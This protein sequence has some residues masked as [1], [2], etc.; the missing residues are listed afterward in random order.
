MPA[1]QQA[2]GGVNVV[3]KAGQASVLLQD[4][5]H[6]PLLE[7]CLGAGALRL[8]PCAAYCAAGCGLDSCSHAPACPRPT[9]PRCPGSA[10]PIPPRAVEAG[11]RGPSRQ[12]VQAYLGV[13][14]GVWSYNGVVKHWEPVVEPWDV[15]AQ[16]AANYGSKVGR[17]GGGMGRGG[18]GQSR[19]G[20]RRRGRQLVL[21]PPIPVRLLP[22]ICPRCRR[23]SSRAWR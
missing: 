19:A 8:C 23:A 5:F 11:V 10:L 9:S 2:A 22:A 15:I 20:E 4:T 3:V 7:L 13:K 16:C 18:G 14:L 1:A 12:V 6:V 17:G 21:S